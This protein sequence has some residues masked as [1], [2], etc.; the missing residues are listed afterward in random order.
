MLVPYLACFGQILDN[1]PLALRADA[2]STYSL[3]RFSDVRPERGRQLEL[4]GVQET[5][6]GK[7]GH[8]QR[9][10]GEPGSCF[11]SAKID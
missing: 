3:M 8:D 1:T 6:R 5:V 2:I 9:E 10:C 7:S 11:T 4:R